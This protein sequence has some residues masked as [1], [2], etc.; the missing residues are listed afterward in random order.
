MSGLFCLC[1]HCGFLKFSPHWQLASKVDLAP[2]DAAAMRASS[3]ALHTLFT[4]LTFGSFVV[5][6]LPTTDSLSGGCS[7]GDLFSG[8]R[9]VIRAH[10]A[11][12]GIEARESHT[13]I[14]FHEYEGR[15]KYTEAILSCT[16]TVRGPTG[17]CPPHITRTPRG[18]GPRLPFL[19]RS[20]A[21]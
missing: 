14:S 19:V 16:I 11:H 21:R 15:W 3:S 18:P 10:L 13:Y 1:G 20:E 9:N 2:T 7:R 4:M 8:L 5:K 17:K 12:F 6:G